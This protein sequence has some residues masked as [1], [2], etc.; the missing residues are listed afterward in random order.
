MVKIIVAVVF[1]TAFA[2]VGVK[3]KNR[4]VCRQ[5]YW[6]FNRLKKMLKMPGTVL[7]FR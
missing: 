1:V 5:K 4:Q 2:A 3:E 7:S 6:K